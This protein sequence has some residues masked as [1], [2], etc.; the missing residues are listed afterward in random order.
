MEP[1]LDEYGNPIE[2]EENKELDEYGNP[3]ESEDT[4]KTETV[5][6]PTDAIST[7][8]YEGKNF[9]E[10][11]EQYNSIIEG[12]NVTK[13][14]LGFIGYA[15]YNDPDT[16]RREYIP[17]PN[18][19]MFG[20]NGLFDNATDM[21]AGLITG[22]MDRAATAFDDTEANVSTTSKLILGGSESL[23]DL[24]E[25]GAAGLEV[26]GVDGAVD[27]VKPLT[28]KIDTGD[29]IVDTILTDAVPAVAMAF[30][31]GAAAQQIV[32]NMPP[33]LRGFGILLGGELGATATVG[34]EEGTMFLGKGDTP[35]LFP[36]AAGI[37][38]GDSEAEAILEQRFNTLSEGM[39][40]NST[41]AGLGLTAL[42]VA[43]MVSKFAITPFL[44]MAS[45]AA[46]ESRIYNSISDQLVNINLS[47]TKKQIA[48]AK[49]AI[50]DIIEK[51]KILLVPKLTNLV[52]KVPI[53]IDTIS[54]LLKGTSNPEDIARI[55]GV[56]AGQ[57]QKGSTAAKTI[58]ASETPAREL[59]GQMDELLTEVGGDTATDQAGTIARAADELAIDARAAINTAD[60]GASGA[61]NTFDGAAQRVVENIKN[62]DLEI[63][64][65]IS[66][67]EDVT[68]TNI[69][70]G[71]EASFEEI[72]SGL[73]TAKETMTKTKDDLYLNVPKG[74]PFDY[75]GF[76]TAVDDAVKQ[77]DLLDSSGTRTKSVELINT[78]RLALKPR[79]VV[80]EGAAVPFG[81]RQDVT[82]VVDGSDLATELL[83]GGVDFRTL[84]TRVRPEISTLI[85]QAYKRGD[86]AVA[87]RL[88]EVK[89]AIDLQVEWV[90]KN[91]DPNAANAARAAYDYY[92]ETYAPIWRSGGAIQDFG[93]MYQPVLTRGTGQA[94][95]M[96]DSRSLV[97]AVL[98]GNNADAVLNM[99]TALEQVADPKPIADYM[100]TDVVNGFASS[101]RQDG[102][103]PETLKSMSSRLAQYAESLNTAFPE[104][105]AQ[106]NRL[107]A[108]IEEAG[109]NKKSVEAALKQAEEVAT[110]TRKDVKSS[111][112]GKFLSNIY[113]RELDTTLNPEA[114]FVKIF[115]ETEGVG[116]I[117]DILA[118]LDDMPPA[119]SRVIRDGIEASFLRHL[120]NRING[121]KMQSGG[122][123]SLKGANVDSILTELNNTL[124]IGRA[125]FSKSPEMMETVETLLDAARIIE[126]QKQ[127]SPVASMSPTAFNQEAIQ[128]T[129]R[130]ILTFIGPLTRFGARVSALSGTIFDKLDSTQRAAKIMDNMLADPDYFLE[131]ARKYNRYPMDPL[132]EEN[133]ITALTAGATKGINAEVEYMY[134]Q[135]N[136]DQQMENLLPQ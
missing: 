68:G 106:I 52:E 131:L 94:G 51:N 13:P 88:I 99:R 103:T 123:M 14:P 46:I 3:V 69:V 130:L 86:N 110:Q 70:T 64:G 19:K 92:S 38:L 1:E 58:A 101:V 53:P 91:S 93:D 82:S 107:V 136:V 84:Y 44:N 76:A 79:E 122:A 80:Q 42:Q 55:S 23:G 74:T 34:T 17:R 24:V 54:A 27:F 15:V 71:K 57:I 112:L 133:L 21:L 26:A 72:R 61:Q 128:A 33:V 87:I 97:T 95:F 18:Q 73:M 135:N 121:A 115:R 43:K 22:D 62:A 6:Q 5:A 85:D 114:A 96:E 65:T 105:A 37:D 81:V 40:L 59:Q 108:S 41:I 7:Q 83:E 63:G 56:R 100:I 11:M 31:G 48:D 134:D 102:M 78:I 39:L 25:A 129:N 10:A 77:I 2:S 120:G 132:V 89:K 90:A 45:D 111:E 16:G 30:T 66:R 4:T 113:G 67:L 8:M 119:R 12:P 35:T 36:I 109:G 127:A 124:D 32:K 116:T 28:P 49:L 50:A 126:K 118:R 75:G 60:A 117:Q 104:R 98:Q 9:S 47:S 20:E 29:S 125:V